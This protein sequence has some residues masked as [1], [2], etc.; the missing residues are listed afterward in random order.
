MSWRTCKTLLILELSLVP[1][2]ED[3]V[4]YNQW[5]INERQHLFS[6]YQSYYTCQISDVAE[7]GDGTLDMLALQW[8]EDQLSCQ[9]SMG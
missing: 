6:L 1:S 5:S 8:W 9:Q 2:Y 7:S 4:E 3:L